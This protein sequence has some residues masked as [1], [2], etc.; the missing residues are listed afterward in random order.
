MKLTSETINVFSISNAI[1][2]GLLSSAVAASAQ[3]TASL[4][5]G[6]VECNERD[7]V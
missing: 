7:G 5:C 3:T 1:A 2:S 6:D 4:S